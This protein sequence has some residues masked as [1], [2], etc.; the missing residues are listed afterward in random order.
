M[1]TMNVAG[2]CYEG[3]LTEGRCRDLN[4]SGMFVLERGVRY[5]EEQ[6]SI[7]GLVQIVRRTGSYQRSL[8]FVQRPVSVRLGLLC[9][10]TM[11]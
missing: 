2:E 9:N 11:G 3:A 5:S 10:C 1:K 7:A 6:A 8:I 4:V